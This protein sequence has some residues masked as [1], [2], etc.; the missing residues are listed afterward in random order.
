MSDCKSP[1]PIV[2]K[3][4]P[5]KDDKDNTV[6]PTAKRRDDVQENIVLK[7]KAEENN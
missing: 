3:E 2:E 7:P 6:T 5:P 4:T 1:E